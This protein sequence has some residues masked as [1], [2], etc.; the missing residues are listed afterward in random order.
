MS[1]ASSSSVQNVLDRM[2]MKGPADEADPGQDF[3]PSSTWQGPR[4]GYYFGTSDKGTGYYLDQ[5][6]TKD[7]AKKKRGVQI[8]ESNNEMRLFTSPK[9]L[10][11]QAEQKALGST[12]V[13]LTPKGIQS[14]AVA[15]DKLFQKN[16]LQ[17]AQYAD[18]PQNYMDSE[19]ALHDQL[20]ALTAVAASLQL[21]E[22]IIEHPTLLDTL[23][24]LLGHENDDIAAI[25][26]S[27]YLEWLDPTLLQEA[28]PD[29][30]LTLGIL[31]C[32]VLTEAWETIVSNFARFQQS[33]DPSSVLSSSTQDPTLKGIENSLS[34]ME[35]LLDLDL[36]IPGGIVRAKDDENEDSSTPLSAA[37]Y[38]VQE[39]KIVSWLL[40]QIEKEGSKE[41]ESVNVEFQGRCMELVAFVAQREDVHSILVDWSKLP[42]SSSSTTTGGEPPSKKAKTNSEESPSTTIDGIE[43]MLQMIGKFRKAQPSNE[44]E[45]G[46]LENACLALSSCITFSVANLSAF[47]NGQGIEL[48]VRCLKERVHSG[49]TTLKLLDFVGND[50]E[51]QRACERLVTADGLKYLFPLFLG[52]RI[53]KPAPSYATSTKDKKEWLNSIETQT[54]LIFYSL[55]RHLTDQSPDDAK[56]RFLA[57]FAQDETKCDR[58]VELLL[59]YDEK[60]RKAEF[61]FYRSDVE[62]VVED[63][64]TIQLAALDA[65]LKGGGDLFHRLGAL[66]AYLA[67]HSKRCHERILA[68]LKL[69]Q[70]GVSLVKMAVDEFISLLEEG[71]PQ[72][73]QLESYLAK[74]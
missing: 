68:Q 10:L 51:H 20:Q 1:G 13:E 63:E 55:S 36:A 8:D 16:A 35:N 67:A 59:Y 40:E 45:T 24:Q 62:E 19:L 9:S 53:P 4:P 60:S 48:V 46:I 41:S 64:E 5:P 37:A 50:P 29:G 71:S 22:S 70:S 66:A 34:L 3:Y 52:T 47:L 14:A 26:V 11:E 6:T 57:K 72:R 43:C 32:R 74:I 54:V 30:T 56:A 61:Q 58:L 38:M 25:V 73:I 39:T 15:L 2:L 69:Q 12:I 65:K 17:R 18:E 44:N 27:L 28:D 42:K 7:P 49:A 21:Y 23:T 33:A 31:A